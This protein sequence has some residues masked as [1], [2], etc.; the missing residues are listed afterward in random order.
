MFK[1][2]IDQYNWEETEEKIYS[3]TAQEVENALTKQGR[4]T[5]DDFMA[6]ISPAAKP[7]LEPMAALSRKYTQ[8]RFGKT[9]QMFI[10]LYITNSCTNHCIYCGFNINND[11]HRIVLDETQILEEAQ[12][13]KQ[14][15]DFQNVIVLTGE[16]PKVA[17]VDYVRRALELLRSYF[18]NLSVEIPPME[19][20][21]Y[22][23]LIDAGLNGVTCFQETYHEARYKVYHPKGKKSNYT[24]RVNSY[25]R[26]GLAGVHKIGLGVLIGLEDWRTDLTMMALHL[27]YMEKT[28]WQ[29]KYA[30][31]FPRIR[32]HEGKEFQPNSIMDDRE[33][34]QSIFAFRLFDHDLDL[35]L[36]TRESPDFR[37]HMTTLGLTSISAGSKTDPG[38][39][40]VYKSELEQFMINDDRAPEVVAAAVKVQGYEVIWKDWDLCLQ[41]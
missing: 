9:M 12:A 31:S 4:L 6:L 39:Y 8:E 40:S 32:P 3:K 5:L 34:A 15:G 41:S 35:S 29:T 17:N 18:S 33:L 28:Y 38:G 37:D 26:M 16:N 27:R 36:S 24:W 1:D 25:D 11:I 30:V 13:I 2:L 19:V 22:E 23:Q 10:P 14:L 21:E 20:D 7:Y